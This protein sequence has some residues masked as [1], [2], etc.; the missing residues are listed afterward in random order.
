[1]SDEKETYTTP[2]VFDIVENNAHSA[3]QSTM[4]MM[5][6]YCKQHGIN[7]LEKKDVISI[8]GYATELACSIVMMVD[9]D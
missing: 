9:S 5:F 2:S 7:D 3:F 1:M 8:M 4:N 6:N